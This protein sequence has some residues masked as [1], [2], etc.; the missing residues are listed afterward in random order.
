MHKTFI[1][2]VLLLSFLPGCAPSGL[3]PSDCNRP[4][5]WASCEN[6]QGGHYELSGGA[7]N[8][9]HGVVGAK[10][11]L[12]SDGNDMRATLDSA[13][14]T[15]DIV[16]LDGSCGPF[17][18]SSTIEFNG[19][20]NKTLVG[21]N[22][23]V[24]RSSF[25]LT[26]QIKEAISQGDKSAVFMEC[27]F[28][29]FLNGSENIILRNLAFDGPGS[30]RGLPNPMINV[31]YGSHN[32]W[33]DHCL[34]EDFARLAIGVT[35]GSDCVT[36]SWCEFRIT[37]QSNGHSLGCL[38]ASGDDNWEDEDLLNVTF[39]H[40]LWRNVWSRVPMARFGTIHVINNWYDCAGTV[41]IN[42]RQNSEFLV[43]GCWFEPGTNPLCRYKIEETPPKAY[44]FRDNVFDPSYE[45]ESVGEV[46]VPYPYSC[47]SAEQAKADV[48]AFAGPTLT[49]PLRISRQK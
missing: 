27:G 21:I 37:E 8:P 19:L 1:A 13:M 9:G 12:Q 45:V 4:V 32:I 40:C 16:V 41:G 26:P 34:F 33:I 24:L 18:I 11:I 25:Q 5:G 35:K 30:V 22:R 31:R 7:Y 3:A 49:R 15:Y 20:R 42:P 14:R 28:F 10:C 29:R 6:L 39:D 48:S 38:I 43:E 23:A 2:A 36:V 17:E 47:T 46:I 44:I